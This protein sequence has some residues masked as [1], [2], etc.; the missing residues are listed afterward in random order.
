MNVFQFV[1]FLSRC[2]SSCNCCFFFF[3]SFSILDVGMNCCLLMF[4]VDIVVVFFPFSYAVVWIFFSTIFFFRSLARSFSFFHEL[5][6]TEL[7]D[8]TILKWQTDCFFVPSFGLYSF[9]VSNRFSSIYSPTTVRNCNLFIDW[10]YWHFI[11]VLMKYDRHCR[12]SI[13]LAHSGCF[14]RRQNKTSERKN[15]TKTKHRRRITHSIVISE[16][17]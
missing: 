17:Q 15:K 14:N 7:R 1:A 6:H 13:L 3:A 16:L 8:C 11:I 9:I 2:R 10:I 12:C 5:S 4:I